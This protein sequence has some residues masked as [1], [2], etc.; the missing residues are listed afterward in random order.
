MDET[1]Y[2]S[3]IALADVEDSAQSYKALVGPALQELEKVCRESIPDILQQ[4][5][6]QG[7]IYL[8]KAEVTR[9][10]DWKL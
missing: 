9:L 6:Q 3:V 4:R 5:K 7:D 8:E 1:K 2:P 10:M